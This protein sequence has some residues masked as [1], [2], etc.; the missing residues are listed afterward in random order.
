[1][2]SRISSN[3][4][5]GT[6]KALIDQS[7]HAIIY[8][9]DRA[10]RR[11]SEE[12]KLIKDP[13]KV[14]SVDG[15]Q[16]EERSRVNFAQ[17]YPIEHN[18]KVLEVGRVADRHLPMF[19]GYWQNEEQ[20]GFPKKSSIIYTR[21]PKGAKSTSGREG[22]RGFTR[23][24]PR[25]EHVRKVHPKSDKAPKR[26]EEYESVL[27][28][29]H[30]IYPL[31]G[32][33]VDRS[34]S[35]ISSR[36]SRENIPADR[37]CYTYKT[38]TAANPNNVQC[39]GLS[40]QRT[41]DKE[42]ENQI[43]KEEKHLIVKQEEH[44]IIK[45]EEHSTAG[46]K[47]HLNFEEKE[48]AITK[49]NQDSSAKEEEHAGAKEEEHSIVQEERQAIAKKNEDLGAEEEEH[50]S[51]MEDERSTA[52]GKEHLIV[53]EEEF[54]I[55]GHSNFVKDSNSVITMLSSKTSIGEIESRSYKNR[56]RYA[57][58]F[59]LP[60]TLHKRRDY[61]PAHGTHDDV[62]SP[63]SNEDDI[64]SRPP[65]KRSSYEVATE[66]YMTKL[67][68]ENE[69]LSPLYEEALS[70]LG[71]DRFI[72]NFRRLLKRYY[73]DLSLR[74]ETDSERAI[75]QLLRSRWRRT[76]IAMQIGHIFRPVIE[77]AHSAS[78]QHVELQLKQR[79]KM[80][81]WLADNNDILPPES[82]ES[83][84]SGD[85]ENHEGEVRHIMN[86]M[87]HVAA[88]AKFL[89]E[90]DAFPSLVTRFRLLLL[91][92]SI[93]SLLRVIVSIPSD[94][95]WMEKSTDF[96][97]SNRVK[98]SIEQITQESWNWWPFRPTM[99]KIQHDQTRVHWR[100]VSTRLL[101]H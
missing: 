34:I 75:N 33:E 67:L 92:K 27:P 49:E 69:Q 47:K 78:A 101:E 20:K 97:F 99:R 63:P 26:S 80:E 38:S 15:H 28:T 91:P 87:P 89:L 17:Q 14:I 71:K 41:W 59:R 93:R 7:E 55:A 12:K 100:C 62:L 50:L 96:S 2:H 18:V 44:S 77:E 16:L 83:N 66:V 73:I 60:Q 31:K 76:E 61:A 45:R 84:Y 68:A 52:D 53:E 32:S 82:E 74:A 1:M 39:Q 65:S 54:S 29:S 51:P 79:T 64:Q 24:D 43:T 25:K 86:E 21:S 72:N 36:H 8:T 58:K 11:L 56:G 94:R 23:E 40:S 42:Q 57:S 5:R 90:S 3:D 30:R 9:G 13:I 46:E 70:K 6:A 95:L 37:N 85:E 10:P 48:T 19:L 88:M 81:D 98:A 22:S 35:P 4:N